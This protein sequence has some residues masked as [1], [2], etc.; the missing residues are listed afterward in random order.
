MSRS[1]N[2][3]ALYAEGAQNRAH[4]DRGIP[5]YVVEHVRAI[6]R[7]VP[8][9]I[10]SVLLNPALPLTG[11]LSW[12]LGSGL[13]GW[14]TD[15]R[16]VMRRQPDSPGVYHIMSPFELGT[17]LETMWPAWA[18]D[19]RVA[20]VVTLYDLIPL[21]FPDHYLSNTRL[22]AEYEARL[23]LIRHADRV[24]AISQTTA[25]DAIE[26]LGIADDQVSVIH[27]GS[28]DTFAK[29]Y[30]TP[31]AARARLGQRLKTIRRG[32]MMYVGGFE[33]RKNL[34]GLIDGYSRLP[35]AVRAAHQ[36]VIV[37]RLVPEQIE[38]LERRATRAGVA[39]GELI[40]TG[41]VSDEELGALYH[42]CSLFVFASWYEGSGLPILEAMSCGAPVAA[43]DT[44]TSPEIL[45]DRDAT[46][47]PHDV[48]SIATCLEEVI[49][50]P[51]T[52][53]RL[54]LRSRGRA[55][56]Y[57][58]ARVAEQT[59]EA[60]AHTVPRRARR[61]S[62]RP[63]LALVTPWPLERSGV[64]DY[65]LRLAG[66]LGDR[67]DVDV[68]VP[69]STREY[70]AP[71]ESGVRLIEADDYCLLEPLRQ[72]D[73]ILYCMGNSMFHGHVFELLR[74]RPGAVLCHDVQLTGFYGWLAGVE[75]P[76]DPAG[77]L[78]ERINSM[79]GRR[80]G[81]EITAE[82]A[83]GWDRQLALGIYMT[84]EIQ[85]YAETCFVHSRFAADLLELDRA[86]LDRGVQ[87]GVLPFGMP[88]ATGEI[89]A[90]ANASPL[91][92]SM[93]VVNEIKGVATLIDA[94]A[95]LASER[96]QA[97][98]VVAGPTDD[99]ESRRWHD[100][101]RERA[102]GASIEIPGH[103]DAERYRAL[104]RD[105]DVAVQLRLATNGEASAAI[106]DCLAAGLPTIVTDLGW[107]GELPPETV[108]QVPP[109]VQSAELAE[110]IDRL[111]GDRERRTSLSAAALS[112]ASANGFESVADACIE[113]LDLS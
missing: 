94:F 51:E 103:V 26:R 90:E 15:D 75:R 96:P 74:R 98:L 61:R 99:A 7:R 113:S 95:T 83:P 59:I 33:F 32:F 79:Y 2:T 112:E 18:R 111:L 16:R 42:A 64:A 72:H 27:A 80:F 44:S 104:L 11:N 21:V 97:R 35:A 68:V 53:A 57:T 36:L 81:S 4:F 54:A 78:A 37:C 58:W 52:L 30:A 9:A 48:T 25:D 29:M 13:L 19:P 62:R 86:P 70:P 84:R 108:V 41:Y 63:R 22:R 38:S 101:A 65:S 106:A 100:Y 8:E 93:G 69:R 67:V 105:A 107:S 71:L 17:S 50:S 23:E 10:H 34:E 76:E 88:P 102:P 56:G 39:A 1:E 47:D 49:T 60:Y 5:R 73:R 87:V 109:G 24:L 31:D 6:Q 20:T 43:S 46:F 82:G 77:A 40:L 89:R 45:G 12:L 3:V 66:A 14:S 92:V 28:T 55:E 110:H 85:L 91:I